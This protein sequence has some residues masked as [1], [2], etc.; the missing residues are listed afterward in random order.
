MKF[1]NRSAAPEPGPR[2]RKPGKGRPTPTRKEAEAR[3]LR[4]LVVND[5]KL[6][7]QRDREARA[8]AYE[9]QRRAMETGDE[10][11][12]PLRDK[13]RARR[14][15]RD[16]VDARYNLGELFLPLAFFLIIVM[17][18]AGRFPDIA[19][20]ATFAMYIV[21]F[22]GIFDSLIMVFFM[23]RRM[24][25]VL[26]EEDLR[27]WTGMYAFSRS[28]MLRPLRMPKPQ[29]SR[30]WRKRRQTPETDRS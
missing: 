13:G 20:F 17:L 23:K 16:Y 2:E 7:R 1:R 21:V 6:A 3:N 10:R 29:V 14:F 5:K 4:P 9:R 24:R 22:G 15:A 8:K 18:F 11:F 25:A 30:S 28:F 19:F 12:M 26:P 27:K